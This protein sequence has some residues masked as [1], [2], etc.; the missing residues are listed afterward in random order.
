[1]ETAKNP[2]N[3]ERIEAQLDISFNWGY[4]KTRED[5]RDLYRKSK[6]AQWDGETRLDWSIDVD[7]EKAQIPEFMHPLYGSDI[8]AKLD[9][10]KHL[11]LRREMPAW[12]Q[13]QF[14]HGEQGAM[15]VAA[16]LVSAVPDI[17]SKLYASTQV[18][19][20]AR[21]VEVFDRYLHEKVGN[22]YPI[23]PHLRAL[24]D[25]IL[26]DSRWD[27]KLLGMQIMV[28]GL[29]L[30]AFGVTRAY[31]EEPLLQSLTTYVI[32]DEARH[33]AYGVLSL[34]DFY[35]DQKESEVREREDFVYEAAVLM[36]DRFLFQEVWEKTGLPVKECMEITLNNAGQ[37]EFRKILFSKI[38]PAVKKAGLL[39]DRQ[40]ERF[41]KLGIL[42]YENWQDPFEALQQAEAEMAAE[43]AA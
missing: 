21:H 20:E 24:L 31:I 40:R 16:Q 27:M 12:T 3:V 30:A 18:M 15:L 17:E 39:S 7:I 26:K 6:Q 8:Y 9:E 42:E 1:M 34:R 2:V 37:Q 28:E 32:Q 35:R 29:A 4:E 25:R 5:L 33:V 19:D 43:R 22:T 13:S 41:A 38:V 23:S 11:E 10:K 36:R 14:L